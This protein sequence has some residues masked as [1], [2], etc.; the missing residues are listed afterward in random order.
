M[1]ESTEEKAYRAR[2]EIKQGRISIKGLPV[3]RYDI[4]LKFTDKVVEGISLRVPASG[5]AVE[6]GKRRRCFRTRRHPRRPGLYRRV[7]RG[8]DGGFADG[9]A[10]C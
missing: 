10:Y 5:G 9:G 2:I 3:G 4:L 6:S 8:Q 1:D 7:Y